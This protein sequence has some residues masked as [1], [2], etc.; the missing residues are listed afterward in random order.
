[1]SKQNILQITQI[2]PQ[3]GCYLFKDQQ[4]RIIYVGKAKKLRQRIAHHFQGNQKYLGLIADWEIILTNNVK[5]ALILE[6]NLIKK[7]QPRFNILLRDDRS[8]P[9]IKITEEKNPRYWLVK[10]VNPTSKDLYFGPFPDGTKTAEIL[11]ILE[12]VFPLAKCKGDLGKP[13]L[14]YSLRQCSGHC[15]KKVKPEY[16]QNI[17]QKIKV[18]TTEY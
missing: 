8:Y 10:K 1:M 6:Q 5:E 15:F 9:Y 7:H 16:Y 12:K 17:K 4:K 2:P 3:T 18:Y 11:Q 14:D 13:C